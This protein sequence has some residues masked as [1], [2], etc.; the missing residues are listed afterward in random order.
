MDTTSLITILKTLIGRI[1][2]TFLLT[3]GASVGGTLTVANNDVV[4]ISPLLVPVASMVIPVDK[5]VN[6]LVP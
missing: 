2:L 4:V 3:S 5:I 1:D 6:V